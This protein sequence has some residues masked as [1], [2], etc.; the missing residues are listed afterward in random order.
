MVCTWMMWKPQYNIKLLQPTCNIF[1]EE[2]KNHH[3]TSLTPAFTMLSLNNYMQRCEWQKLCFADF[4]TRLEWQA[5]CIPHANT[6]Q[7]CH[8]HPPVLLSKDNSHCQKHA[9]SNFS[10][11]SNLS[12]IKIVRRAFLSFLLA[13]ALAS[14]SSFLQ[15]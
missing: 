1:L 5:L 6:E 15:W 9:A 2:K 10:W 11:F 13:C 14:A 7:V 4:K 8:W 12:C 3:W